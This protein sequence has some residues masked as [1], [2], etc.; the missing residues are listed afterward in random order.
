PARRQRPAA[1]RAR[2]LSPSMRLPPAA[3]ALRQPAA[4]VVLPLAAYSV[5]AVVSTWPLATAPATHVA[6]PA[7]GA[8]APSL[9][10]FGQTLRALSGSGDAIAPE[11][12]L[13]A[14]LVLPVHL[15]G[16]GVV[17]SHN[18]ALLASLAVSGLAMHACARALGA[19]APGAY[20]A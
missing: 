20:V 1:P 16:A 9:T 7:P 5:A 18:L 8:D 11:S 13:S 12:L 19:D 14:L 10:A 17:L 2:A 6:V 4:R 3:R 15:G